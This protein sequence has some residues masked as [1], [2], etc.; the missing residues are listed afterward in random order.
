[1][2]RKWRFLLWPSGSFH[3]N[4][5][6]ARLSAL[7]QF[8][9]LP[10]RTWQSWWF[11]NYAKIKAVMLLHTHTKACHIKKKDISVEEHFSQGTFLLSIVFVFPHY[12]LNL[13][14]PEE[15]FWSGALWNCKSSPAEQ[16]W[17]GHLFHFILR[18]NLKQNPNEVTKTPLYEYLCAGIILAQKWM[19]LT[20]LRI[21]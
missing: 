13:G 19:G 12:H 15:F 2:C 14:K 11:F 10:P 20:K 17:Q 21:N 8:P 4:R 6:N 1:M 16:H 18:G 9:S 7:V 5:P 3:P